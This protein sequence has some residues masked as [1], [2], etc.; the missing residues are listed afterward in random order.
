[1]RH[2]NEGHTLRPTALVNEAWMRLV[3]Q[4]VADLRNRVHF[5]GVAA[6]VMRRVLVAYARERQ[7]EKRGGGVIRCR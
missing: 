6:R 2:E 4:R 5:F 1:M 3:G 7:A